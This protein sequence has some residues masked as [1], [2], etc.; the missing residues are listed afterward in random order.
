MVPYNNN[1]NIRNINTGINSDA[2]PPSTTLSNVNRFGVI[3]GTT[4]LWCLTLPLMV[5]PTITMIHC[6]IPP[7]NA[8]PMPDTVPFNQQEDQEVWNVICQKPLKHD[9]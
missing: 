1:G 5:L 6:L 7:N 8:W 9:A 2:Y 4:I 3:T